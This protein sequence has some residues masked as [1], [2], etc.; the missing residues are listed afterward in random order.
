M[1]EKLPE[2][3]EAIAYQLM[4]DILFVENKHISTKTATRQD[5]LN[6]YSECSKVVK[7]SSHPQKN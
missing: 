5:I 1:S 4:K 3:P 2:S 6:T 7:F